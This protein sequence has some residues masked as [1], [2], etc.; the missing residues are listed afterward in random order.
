MRKDS[1]GKILIVDDEEVLCRMVARILERSGYRCDLAQSGDAALEIVGKGE[2]ALVVTDIDMPGMSG[3]ELLSQ[4]KH[5]RPD[6]AVIMLTGVDDPKTAIE[7]LELGAY[8]YVIKPFEENELLINVANALRRRKLEQ[9]L[10]EARKVAEH[11]TKAKSEFLANM[12]HEIRTPMNAIMGMCYLTLKT[13]LTPKQRDYIN[14]MHNATQSLLGIIND[15]LDVSKIE[16]GKLELE[17]ID[18]DLS[19]VLENLSNLITQ[20][21][22]EKGLEIV[23][24]VGSDVP[25]AIQGDPL[26]LGQI[27]LNLTSNAVKFTEKGEI[28]ISVKPV[29]VE[30][31]YATLYFAV[32]DTGIGITEEQQAKLF[33]AFQ[34][35][36]TSTTR[37]YSGTGLGLTISKNLTEM[38]GGQIAVESEP[39]KGSVFFFTAKFG[40]SHEQI[41]TAADRKEESSDGLDAIRGAHILLV[42]DNEI[43]QQ[44]ARELLQ[45][46]GFFVSVANNGREAVEK[47]VSKAEN[48]AYDVVL[49]DLQMPVMDGYTAAREIRKDSR[50]NKLPIIAMTADAMDSVRDK[51]LDAGMNDY[52]TKP[53]SPGDLFR[54]LVKCIKPGS[55]N[56]QQG[57]SA[58]VPDSKVE[59]SEAYFPDILPGINIKEALN[60]VGG[61]KSLFRKLLTKFCAGYGAA[62]KEIVTALESGDRKTASRLIH[63]LKGLSGNI[64]ARELY[65]AAKKLEAAVN[66]EKEDLNDLLECVSDNLNM[67]ISGIASL[68]ESQSVKRPESAGEAVDI[69]KVAPLLD[70][71]KTLLEESDMDAVKKLDHLKDVLKRS[72]WHDELTAVEQSISKYDS[73]KALRELNSLIVRLKISQ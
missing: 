41:A 12:S 64:G 71:L 8:G 62:V 56:R 36:D 59:Q 40:R 22:Q 5:F 69:T 31:E 7:S 3:L 57:G 19:E 61:D 52:V 34:Q 33:Q 55:R 14:K 28:V 47:V 20:T 13:D 44:I 72:T 39:D 45:S 50:Q 51:A 32:K 48:E 9:M 30:S 18:F 38:M 10:K 6:I 2:I 58:T 16:A 35:A 65:E 66:E 37:K 27:L 23:F 60:R 54:A 21:A 17:T 42:E 29:E 73:E 24:A 11:A 49:M 70:E 26:R 67:V 63:T 25:M 4:I 53:I 46:E 68:D 15:I 1:N 43:N